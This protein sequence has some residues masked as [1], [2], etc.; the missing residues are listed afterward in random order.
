MSAVY[1]LL[2]ACRS[3]TTD[4]RERYYLFAILSP[5]APRLR[6]TAI[7]RKNAIRYL[8]SDRRYRAFDDA[9]GQ[10]SY[11]AFLSALHYHSTAPF[12]QRHPASPQSKALESDMNALIISR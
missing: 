6:F 3:P 12:Y 9:S 4:E 1:D 11:R 7:L 2:P 10:F 5:L 8:I